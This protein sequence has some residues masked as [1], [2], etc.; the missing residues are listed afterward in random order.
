MS[1]KSVVEVTSPARL[2]AEIP[3]DDGVAT[4][5]AAWRRSIGGVLTG[6]DDR[7][8]VVVGP[9]S[10]H[11]VVATRHYANHLREPLVYRPPWSSMRATGT[12]EKTTPSNR[13]W[14][15]RSELSS[16]AGST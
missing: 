8:L 3:A 15:P 2:L 12:A 10:V 11:D 9:C 4:K 1:G 13:R 5:V 16:R 6:R 7:V 14:S